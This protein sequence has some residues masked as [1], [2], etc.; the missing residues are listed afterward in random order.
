MPAMPTLTAPAI[1]A[2]GLCART[3]NGVRHL[4]L[5]FFQRVAAARGC[6]V[7][8]CFFLGRLTRL[9]A[10]RCVLKMSSF[11]AAVQALIARLGVA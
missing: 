6:R 1:H 3:M 11:V 4:M 2:R 9:R 8:S 7:F 5:R 10:A